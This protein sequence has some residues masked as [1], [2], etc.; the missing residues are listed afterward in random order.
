[1]KNEAFIKLS[2]NFIDSD[3]FDSQGG[4]P[5]K[6]YLYLISKANYMNGKFNGQTIYPGE[7]ARSKTRLAN[8]LGVSR[9]TL[10]S[11]LQI[12][13]NHGLLIVTSLDSKTWIIT[14]SDY[15]AEK[16]FN[17]RTEN[18]AD[19]LSDADTE[20]FADV[21]TDVRTDIDTDANTQIKNKE[22]RKEK[23]EEPKFKSEREMSDE[24]RIAT[25]EERAKIREQE[26]GN[27]CVIDKDGCVYE[28]V[29]I[30]GEQKYKDEDGDIYDY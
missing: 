20:N 28:I 13:I 6:T 5:L 19:N 15:A 24:E 17:H 29:T 10:N 2:K 27:K 23:K 25:A 21:Y 8:Q 18:Y 14:L 3:F 11:H 26:S 16:A 1:M 4:S 22:K 12:L 9:S 7:L 30:N